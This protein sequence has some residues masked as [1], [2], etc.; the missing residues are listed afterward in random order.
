MRVDD[1]CCASDDCPLA[2]AILSGRAIGPREYLRDYHDGT[3]S[4]VGLS[5]APVIDPDGTVSGGVVALQDIDEDKRERQRLSE[6]ASK[7]KDK[8]ATHR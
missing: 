4:W 7:I 3:S 1:Y 8:L 6:L 5:A 2:D